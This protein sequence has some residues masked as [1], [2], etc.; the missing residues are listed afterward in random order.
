[1]RCIDAMRNAVVAPRNNS[2]FYK[3]GDAIDNDITRSV[4]YTTAS[5]DGKVDAF[6]GHIM[7]DF[8]TLLS[9]NKNILSER[10]VR[11]DIAR[12]L[13]KAKPEFDAL[14]AEIEAIKKQYPHESWLAVA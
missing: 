12:F 1:M 10:L 14:D 9:K 4:T 11:K 5:L 13:L 3:M 6:F 7:Q 2:P 8:A